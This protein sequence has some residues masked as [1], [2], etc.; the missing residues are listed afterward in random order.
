MEDADQRMINELPTSYVIPNV[1]YVVQ[2]QQHYSASAVV[3]M[4]GQ[5]L[6]VSVGTQSAI[7]T[8][9]GWDV[10]S[11]Y[12]HATYKE[13]F[14]R[15]LV[16][17]GIWSASYYPMSFVATAMGNGTDATA[18]IR[19]NSEVFS[20]FDFALF[21]LM[22]YKC[23]SPCKIR[24][25]FTT[26]QYPMSA[27]LIEKIDM[28]GHC[29]LLVGWNEQGFVVHDPWDKAA[30]GG[31]RGGAYITI[32]YEELIH[33]LSVV[34]YTLEEAEP[35]R[36]PD[37]VL[38]YKSPSVCT[39]GATVTIEAEWRWRGVKNFNLK[40]IRVRNISATLSVG[41]GASI[42]G[43]PTIVLPLTSL[44]LPGGYVRAKWSVVMPGTTGSY[45]SDVTF[46]GTRVFPAIPW[47]GFSDKTAAVSEVGR[48]RFQVFDPAYLSLAGVMP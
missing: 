30:W 33:S 12:T 15:Y 46:N 23:K 17:I 31:T 47:E 11:A 41:G 19:G 29:V 34:N 27:G 42:I 16:D 18:F 37:A 10:P 32:P 6:G 22:L 38:V 13:V 7:A 5:L 44:L 36:P 43:P 35:I 8:A 4:I 45:H 3:Q 40:G 24:L 9:A 26:D 25:H 28:T 39:Y 2:Q 21:K 14:S 1:P 20:Q 48:N